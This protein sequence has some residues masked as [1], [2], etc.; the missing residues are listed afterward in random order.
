MMGNSTEECSSLKGFQIPH[1]WTEALGM[2]NLNF[3]N[4]GEKTTP[5]GQYISILLLCTKL[6]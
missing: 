3:K 1:E 6:P 2:Y 5:V 4:T